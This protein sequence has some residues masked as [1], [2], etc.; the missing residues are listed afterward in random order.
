[1]GVVVAISLG[2]GEFSEQGVLRWTAALDQEN[3][4]AVSILVCIT[5]PYL[6]GKFKRITVIAILIIGNVL[7]RL[8]A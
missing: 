3:A 7:R 2:R 1:L 8:G 6:A 4:C 5:I